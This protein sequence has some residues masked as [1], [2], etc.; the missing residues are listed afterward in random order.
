MTENKQDNLNK[1]ARN[2]MFL[3]AVLNVITALLFWFGY[4][5]AKEEQKIYFLIVVIVTL[6]SSIIIVVLAQTLMKK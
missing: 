4:M 2:A 5:H 6:I 1:K 3:V